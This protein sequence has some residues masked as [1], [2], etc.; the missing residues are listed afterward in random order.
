MLYQS[1]YQTIKGYDP[2]FDKYILECPDYVYI[3]EFKLN[4]TAEVAP[5][6]IDEK[7]VY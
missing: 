1:G 4:S 3:F 5:K 2:T 7:A 6:Q